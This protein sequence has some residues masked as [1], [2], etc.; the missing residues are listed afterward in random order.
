MGHYWR[1]ERIDKKLA[2]DKSDLKKLEVIVSKVEELEKTAAAV[3][4]R[5][6][7]ITDLLKSRPLYPYFMSDFVRSVPMGVRV[8]TLSTAGGG[9]SGGALKLTISA[10]ARANEDIAE[11]VRRME[12]SGR[13]SSEE[14][15][16]VTTTE[17]TSIYNF[18]MTA[19]YSAK[20]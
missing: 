10:E 12:E 11:W 14:L 4:A 18:T 20:L 19:T 6:N 7:V 15:G 13:F 2:K 1:Y 5:L 9:S 17:A 3:R 8:K 16:P